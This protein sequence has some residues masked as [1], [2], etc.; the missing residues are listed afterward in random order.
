M[1]MHLSQP[2]G[3]GACEGQ[4]GMSIIIAADADVS[5]IIWLAII[6]I[7]APDADAPDIAASGDVIA[8]AGR[9]SGAKAMPA[10]IK[11]ASSRRMVVW[12]FT[13]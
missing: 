13:P 8:M 7:D 12:H 11:T 3:A 6:C 9:D 2:A 5:S 4:H 1:K 10:I